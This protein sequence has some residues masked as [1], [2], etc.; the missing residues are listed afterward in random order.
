MPST[1]DGLFHF[2]MKLFMLLGVLVSESAGP[3]GKPCRA[4]LETPSYAA[5]PSLPPVKSLHERASSFRIWLTRPALTLN[6]R[7]A[8]RVLLPSERY[9]ARR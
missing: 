7:A 8:S 6:L 3:A 2:M 4:N 9:W 1:G 5:L